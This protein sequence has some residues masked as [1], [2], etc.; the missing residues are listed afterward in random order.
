MFYFFENCCNT[1]Q[2]EQ[3]HFKTLFYYYLSPNINYAGFKTISIR[4]Q[5]INKIKLKLLSSH[6]IKYLSS[7]LH[8]SNWQ[9]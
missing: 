3:G 5:K 9:I 6:Q 2:N 4:F 8:I 7:E 1:D